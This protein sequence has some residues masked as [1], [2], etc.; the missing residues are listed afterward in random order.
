MNP[1]LKGLKNLKAQ[2]THGLS[3]GKNPTSWAQLKGR[4]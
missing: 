2:K 3:L 1:N 4:V